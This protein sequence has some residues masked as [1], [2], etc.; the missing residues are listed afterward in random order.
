VRTL[1]VSE[2]VS[3]DGVVEAPGGEPGFRH[4]GWTQDIDEDPA[5]YAFKLAEAQAADALLLGRRTYEGF[6]AAW[7]SVEGPFGDQFNAMPKYVVSTTL[8]DPSWNGT[9]V[10][11]G[12]DEVA[13]LR[14]GEGGPVLLAGSATLVAGLYDAG[15]VD[16]WRLLVWPV[17][18]GSGQRLFPSDAAEKTKLRLCETRLFANG[19]QLQVLRP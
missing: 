1:I 4:S 5:V 18:L 17:V 7:P 6:A 12:I 2:F 9:T 16:E 19:I 11:G 13:A 3:L 15:L 14:A 10:L 8:T